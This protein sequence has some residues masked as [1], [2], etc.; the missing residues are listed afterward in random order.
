MH[1]GVRASVFHG[2]LLTNGQNSHYLGPE[3][4]LFTASGVSGR[5]TAILGLPGGVQLLADAAG[6]R[7]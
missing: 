2:Q 3:V 6:T 5:G 7:P 4:G 1:P